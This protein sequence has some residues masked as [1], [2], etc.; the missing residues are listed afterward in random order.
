[1]KSF[2][3]VQKSSYR[4]QFKC[5]PL[6]VM[7]ALGAA[8]NV[9]SSLIQS[10]SNKS[11]NKQNIAMQRETNEMQRQMFDENLAWQKESQLLQN[12]YNSLISQVQRALMAGVSPAALF[13]SS[14]GSVPASLGSTGSTIP[15]LSSPHA[16]FV[17]EPLTEM[18]AQLGIMSKAYSDLSQGG[19]SSAQSKAIQEKLSVEI[20]K[21][22]AE[23]DNLN[24]DTISKDIQNNLNKMFGYD[25]RNQKLNLI[26]GNICESIA[27][28]EMYR[29][30]GDMFEA[31]KWLAYAREDL[32][33]SK[34]N[35]SNK[36]Y[37]YLDEYLK[38]RNENVKKDIE[39]KNS[40]IGY[41][42]AMARK[43]ITESDD[44]I[45]TRESRIALNNSYVTLN[46]SMKELNNTRNSFE[47]QTLQTRILQEFEKTS[48]MELL[49]TEQRSNVQYAAARAEQAM[50]DNDM[51]KFTYWTN[52]GCKI[53]DTA[54]NAVGEIKGFKFA[55][56]TSDVTH[57]G[58]DYRLDNY[59][60]IDP[61]YI[62][63]SDGVERRYKRSTSQRHRK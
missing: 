39:V 32:T 50:Y 1:M 29:K 44:L 53:V 47:Q 61:V 33:K 36:E 43:A 59:E 62:R 13:E 19:L 28:A 8:G 30:Q 35:I 34:T 54:A 24:A 38:Y 41:N 55:P 63:D 10:S 3:F 6:A 21:M 22:L 17:K 20:D 42:S 5:D 45:A 23:K 12:E 27:K 2:S 26:R 37:E 46:N 40:T 58:D 15:S 11:I 14:A 57:H 31:D 49:T 56:A 48:Q 16:E 7:A 18:I 60:A 51:K 4:P 9:A 52:W 25:E